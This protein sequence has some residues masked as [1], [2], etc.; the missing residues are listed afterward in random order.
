MMACKQYSEIGAERSLFYKRQR[1][2]LID[3]VVTD[4]EIMRAI[5]EP[6]S[7]TRASLRRKLGDRFNIDKMDW[8]LVVVD[9]DGRRRIELLDPYAT[10]LEASHG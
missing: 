5:R 7:D 10:E 9:D 3:R 4:D 1:A 8:S 6:P 2:G